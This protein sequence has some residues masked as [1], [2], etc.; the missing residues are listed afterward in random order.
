MATRREALQLETRAYPEAQSRDRCC[1]MSVY[2]PLPKFMDGALILSGMM[3]G[4][5]ALAGGSL[6]FG[7]AGRTHEQD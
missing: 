5:G 2:V 6:G 4:G 1:G 7:G 3:R